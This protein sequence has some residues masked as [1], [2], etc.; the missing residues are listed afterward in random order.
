MA[1]QRRA[2]K[3]SAAPTARTR[4]ARDHQ[5][6][7][8]AAVDEATSDP[9]EDRTRQRQRDGQEPELD[10]RRRPHVTIAAIGNARCA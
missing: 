6:T 2:R 9:R 1:E 4:S 7:P 10:E 3:S 5:R 8:A